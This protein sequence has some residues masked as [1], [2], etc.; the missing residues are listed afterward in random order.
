V[1]ALDADAAE[2]QRLIPGSMLPVGARV[3][4][5]RGL[6]AWFAEC[7]RALHSGVVLIIDYII[8]LDDMTARG[9]GWLRTYRDHDRG[10]D[11]LSAP[12]TRD[13]T[14][15]VLREQLERAA[16]AAGFVVVDERSQTQW[17]RDHGIDELVASGRQVWA[18]GAARGDLAAVAGRSRAGE[19]AALTDASGL[20]AHRVV[21]LTKSIDTSGT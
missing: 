16:R 19:A 1:P 2:L 21:T 10:A 14:A 6:D 18:E 12:G 7:G 4:L 17:L 11:P 8:G 13:I 9:A 15:D 3:P 20:G 5:P